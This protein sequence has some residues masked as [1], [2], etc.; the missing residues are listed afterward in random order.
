[1]QYKNHNHLLR[2]IISDAGL[3]GY[4]VII[5]IYNYIY[6]YIHIRIIVYYFIYRDYAK[7]FCNH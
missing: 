1:M 7:F 2:L 6:T 4:M 3:F 5:V